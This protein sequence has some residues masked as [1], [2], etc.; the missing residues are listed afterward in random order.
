[1]S[2]TMEKVEKRLTDLSGALAHNYPEIK[3]HFI[4]QVASDLAERPLPV[5]N[6]RTPQKL[7]SLAAVMQL[8]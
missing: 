2:L 5:V 3:L 1:M 6:S 8:E 7:F 4:L